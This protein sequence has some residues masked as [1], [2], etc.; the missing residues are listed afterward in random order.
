VVVDN[1]K[2]RTT[3]EGEAS[4]EQGWHDITV[5]FS[6]RTGGT[7]I[8]LYWTPPGVSERQLVPS[9]YLSPPMGRYP[10]PDEGDG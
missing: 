7:Q 1:P 9:R 8:Y 5:R 6:D 2:G 10:V 3:I 4:L